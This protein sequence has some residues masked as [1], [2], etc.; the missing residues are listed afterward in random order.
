MGRNPADKEVA[1]AVPQRV[2]DIMRSGDV[3]LCDDVMIGPNVTIV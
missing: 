2:L 1:M 3:Y